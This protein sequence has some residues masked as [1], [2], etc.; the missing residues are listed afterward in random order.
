[1]N[2]V[3]MG[4]RIR[5]IRRA[6]GITQTQLGACIGR[7]QSTIMTMEHGRIAISPAHLGAIC[8]ALDVTV[9]QLGSADWRRLCDRGVSLGAAL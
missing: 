8:A 4:Q 9:R 6:R 7:H 5:T 3:E 2:T 1:M